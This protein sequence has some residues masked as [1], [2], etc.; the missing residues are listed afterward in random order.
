MTDYRKATT[1]E[2]PRCAAT[3]GSPCISSYG[4]RMHL[5]HPS[6]WHAAGGG[7]HRVEGATS[8]RATSM[9]ANPRGIG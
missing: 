2:C 1:V 9:T 8:P 6:R 3:P 7:R 5:L 4:S